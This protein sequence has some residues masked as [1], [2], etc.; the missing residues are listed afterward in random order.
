MID[1]NINKTLKQYKQTI[2]LFHGVID[3]HKNKIRNYNRKHVSKDDFYKFLKKL[4]RIGYSI[5]MD[6][7]YYYYQNNIKLPKKS[8]CITFDDGFYNNYKFAAPILDELKIK[9]T[10]YICSDFVE[11]NRMSWI[12]R[13]EAVV[14]SLKSG[15]IKINNTELSFDSSIKSKIQFL[16]YIRA[17]IKSS[18]IYDPIKFANYFQQKLINSTFDKSNDILDKKMT[19]D[20]IKSIKQNKLFTVGGHSHKHKIFSQM[21]LTEVNKDITK[22]FNFFKEKLKINIQHYSYP[23]GQED[24]FSQREIRILKKKNIIC[25][26]NAIYGFNT[27]KTN[28]FNL[29]RVFVK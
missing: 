10:F 9:S 15:S 11:N 25:C 22:S 1:L 27:R 12:D 28:L 29:N 5:S 7:L 21:T 4:K 8:F 2:F 24:S 14:E 19:I 20:Q 13:I 23:E 3:N 26:P 16:D 17:F 18:K 6:E